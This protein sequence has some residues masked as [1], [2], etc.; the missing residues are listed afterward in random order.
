MTKE[1]SIIVPVYN[2]INL[3]KKF[4]TVKIDFD[5]IHYIIKISDDGTG[6]PKD[7]LDRLGEPYVSKN[8]K[9]MGLGI[10]ISKNLIEN[11][12]GKILFYNSKQNNAIVE[13]KLNKDILL[14]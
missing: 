6:F 12:G 13:I 1:L 14:T 2:E 9:G 7:I 3:I 8:T 4:I 5:K 11:L 10:F